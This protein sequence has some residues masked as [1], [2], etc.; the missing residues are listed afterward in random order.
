MKNWV[1]KS[2]ENQMKKN[3]IWNIIGSMLFA[4]ASIVL[5]TL[6]KRIIGIEAGD[7][8]TF[9]YSVAQMLLTIGYFEIRPFQVTD[10]KGDYEFADYL[11]FRLI[12]SALMLFL[13]ILYVVIF[14]LYNLKGL[15]IIGLTIYKMIDG[16]A[17]V[18]EGEF[19]KQNRID[20]SGKS[21]SF[22][23]IISV[24]CFSI[25]L[26]VTHNIY[27][28]VCVLFLSAS[29]VYILFD[30][31]F[32]QFFAN[33]KPV[34]KREKLTSLFRE[35]LWLALGSIMCVYIFQ[36]SKF[37]IDRYMPHFNYI[38]TTIF[39]PTFIV[40]LASGILFKPML[41]TMTLHY[42]IGEFKLFKKMIIRLTI[43]VAILTIVALGG[44]VL[45]GV[46]IL[47]F[48][49]DVDISPYKDALLWLVLGG[50][51]NALSIVLYYALTV[52]RKIKSIFLVYG[53]CFV[54][55]VTLPFIMVKNDG[56]LGASLSYVLIMVLQTAL[57][58]GLFIVYVTSKASSRALG[59]VKAKDALD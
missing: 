59:E 45:L 13:G 48:I 53:I 19:Q 54:A 44:T 41:S 20:I 9:A 4:L 26:I 8:F 42:K 21:V 16:I 23:V 46:P 31:Y 37:A 6:V 27:M 33:G 15:L 39:M 49:Y 30:M 11:S 10:G 28:A 40:N 22:R 35:T 24:L 58:A 25:A 7:D 34:F 1:L 17:D 2:H 14:A 12:T 47:S 57:F 52:M 3:I 55:S 29:V 56:V 32:I 50:G 51:F 38:Y 18:Y 36:G 43:C 5:V